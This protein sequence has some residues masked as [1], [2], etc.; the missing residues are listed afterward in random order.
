MDEKEKTGRPLSSTAK[1]TMAAAGKPARPPC[2]CI[3]IF[4]IRRNQEVMMIM[5]G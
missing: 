2:V 4:G 5:N 1:P 3:D